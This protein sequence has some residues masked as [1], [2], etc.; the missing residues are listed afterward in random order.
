MVGFVLSLSFLTSNQF[1]DI[2]LFG[3]LFAIFRVLL[4]I[5]DGDIYS[6]FYISITSWLARVVFDNRA[7]VCRNFARVRNIWLYCSVLPTGCWIS[8][9]LAA[10]A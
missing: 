6:F 9:I 8:A 7:A 5:F 1:I 4:I 3:C 2:I 10:L